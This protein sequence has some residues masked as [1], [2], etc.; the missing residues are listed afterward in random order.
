[1]TI[2]ISHANSF[3]ATQAY[4]PVAT[5][6]VASSGAD[7]LQST[8]DAATLMFLLLLKGQQSESHIAEGVVGSTSKLKAQQ[9]EKELDDRIKQIQSEH[10]KGFFDSIGQLVTDAFKVLVSG[11][12][13]ALGDDL[14]AMANS[15]QF[16][17]DLQKI[18]AVVA[19][20]AS[21]VAS[22]AS[23][24]AGSASVVA[25]TAL[26]IGVV[27]S[28]TGMVE[29]NFHV[30][31]KLTNDPEFAKYFTI[32]CMVGSA[33]CG[34]TG[35]AAN[36]LSSAG[37]AAAQAAQT[38]QGAWTDVKTAANTIATAGHIASAVFTVPSAAITFDL[39]EAN[40]DATKR[41]Q[42]QEFL[43]NMIEDI[44]D[45][46]KSDQKKSDKDLGVARQA[47]ETEQETQLTAASMLRA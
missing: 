38:A 16:W 21:T 25:T 28:T 24:G 47:I 32:G 12:I 34:L 3:A 33:V 7:D 6:D 2:A 37:S 31:E 5:E 11:N 30:L 20:V 43:Q 23:F 26:V 17:G 46:L 1:M 15:P 8:A 27:L 44:I 41:S 45:Q 22:V 9:A 14:K 29:Q 4:A 42:Q 13:D 19:E 35:A 18:A 40:I 10:S 36:A 39:A